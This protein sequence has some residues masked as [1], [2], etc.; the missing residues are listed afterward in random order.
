MAREN[1]E[2]ENIASFLIFKPENPF[3]WG[4]GEVIWV[5]YRTRKAEKHTAGKSKHVIYKSNVLRWINKTA[6]SDPK[7]INIQLTYEHL[8]EK[9]LN[10]EE[11]SLE[12]TL[13]WIHQ[14]EFI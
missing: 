4:R 11:L 14:D 8:S 13:V 7:G 2:V 1:R 3:L 6:W 9:E 10:C 5:M 12:S